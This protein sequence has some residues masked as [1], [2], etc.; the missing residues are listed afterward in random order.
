L[1]KPGIKL[2]Q[3]IP[4][5]SLRPSGAQINEDIVKLDKFPVIPIIG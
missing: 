2:I 3:H 5:L 4:K 1:Q